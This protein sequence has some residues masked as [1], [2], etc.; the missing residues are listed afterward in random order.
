MALAPNFSISIFEAKR[1]PSGNRLRPQ[2]RP[3]GGAEP[4]DARPA[5]GRHTN[6]D[7]RIAIAG[8]MLGKTGGKA[9]LTVISRN[10]KVTVKAGVTVGGGS[11]KRHPV[12]RRGARGPQKGT[13]KHGGDA[14]PVTIVVNEVF[15]DRGTLVVGQSGGG[16]QDAK[17][18]SLNAHATAQCRSGGHGGDV[19]ICARD[20]VDMTAAEIE[21]S[22]G[23]GGGNATAYAS[24]HHG[25]DGGHMGIVAHAFAGRALPP[26]ARGVLPGISAKA[27]GGN[28]SNAGKVVF[29]GCVLGG[30]PPVGIAG[31]SGGHANAVGTGGNGGAVN[32]GDATAQGGNGG[33]GDNLGHKAGPGGDA[34][35]KSGTRAR[36]GGLSGIAHATGGRDGNQ[37]PGQVVTPPRGVAGATAS[38]KGKRP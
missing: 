18:Q 31:A 28:A 7:S 23:G 35:A 15:L 34:E 16:G 11:G 37:Q 38:A 26:F 36:I 13:G 9:G 21:G 8:N 22:H 19:V 24:M 10:G 14:G 30:P 20:R 2:N 17:V 12:L 3:H 33:L 32:G 29:Q 5:R 27:V 1:H 25:G 6:L 4:R